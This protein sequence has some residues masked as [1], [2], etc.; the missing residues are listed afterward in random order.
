MTE[1]AYDD[2]LASAD[3]C[4][5]LWQQVLLQAIRDALHGNDVDSTGD[6]GAFQIRKARDYITIPNKDFN[7]VCYLAG[8]DPQAVREHVRPMI[9]AALSPD[10]LTYRRRTRAASHTEAQRC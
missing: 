10:E 1:A 5:A 2:D 8:M 7:E 6:A 3:D 4:A 9:A